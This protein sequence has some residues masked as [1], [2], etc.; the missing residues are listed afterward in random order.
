MILWDHSLTVYWNQTPE[1]NLSWFE[2]IE[3]LFYIWSLDL[4]SLDTYF[5]HSGFEM[6]GKYFLPF[7][8]LQM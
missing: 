8:W 1:K 5:A 6:K 3:N 2:F 4:P 7:F